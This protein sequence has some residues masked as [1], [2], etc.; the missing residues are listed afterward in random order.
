MKKVQFSALGDG[1]FPTSVVEEEDVQILSAPKMA[2]KPRLDPEVTTWVIIMTYRAHTLMK[3]F[4]QVV[5][6]LL[7]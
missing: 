4:I 6:V 7:L 1:H 5:I 2:K 3:V